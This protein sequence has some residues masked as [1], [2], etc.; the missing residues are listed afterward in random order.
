MARSSP[1]NVWVR[2]T[3][4]GSIVSGGKVDR[5]ILF[6]QTYIDG[7]AEVTD[8]ILFPGVRVGR[9]AKVHRCVIDKN[10]D[11]PPG[12]SIGYD[13]DADAAEFVMSERGIVVVQK[14]RVL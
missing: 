6:P 14:D 9:G 3:S 13:H 1:A 8:S 5:S 7:S 4:A 2:S 12:R 11:I 10:V